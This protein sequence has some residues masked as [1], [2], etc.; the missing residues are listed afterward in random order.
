[1]MGDNVHVYDTGR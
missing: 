1:M